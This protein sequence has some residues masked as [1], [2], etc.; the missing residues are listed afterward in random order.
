VATHEG[1]VALA[2]EARDVVVPLAAAVVA[3]VLVAVL[4]FDSAVWGS[5]G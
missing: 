4:E 3:R 1:G 2:V 5:Y